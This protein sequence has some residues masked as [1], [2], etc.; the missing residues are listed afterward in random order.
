MSKSARYEWRDQHAAVNERMKGFLQN[1]NI[2]QLEAVVAEMRAYADAARNGN[3]TDGSAGSA[4]F[5]DGLAAIN[6]GEEAFASN[7]PGTSL[8]NNAPRWFLLNNL[9]EPV[10]QGV[11]E[12][13]SIALLGLAL[14]GLAA[15]RRRKSA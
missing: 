2:E 11:P 12:P 15:S 4:G 3:M 13:T 7:A 14:A 9:G 5:G 6:P 10:P 8:S 1:P